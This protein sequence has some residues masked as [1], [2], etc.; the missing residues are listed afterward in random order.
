MI[1]VAS[2]GTLPSEWVVET[3]PVVR[4]RSATRP[5]ETPWPAF[6]IDLATLAAAAGIAA[7]LSIKLDTLRLGVLWPTLLAGALLALLARSGCYRPALHG[8]RLLAHVLELVRQ[9]GAC[10]AVATF[11]VVGTQALAG[12]AGGRQTF[13]LGAAMGGL[14]VSGQIAR[15][16]VAR[17]AAQRQPGGRRTLIVG[18]GEVGCKA[19]RRLLAHPEFGLLPVCFYDEEPRFADGVDG[20]PVRN[21][22]FGSLLERERIE[23]VIVAFSRTP[24]ERLLQLIDDSQR[25]GV[26]VSLVPRLFEKVPTQ[27]VVTTLG[28]LPLVSLRPFPHRSRLFQLKYA[29]ERALAL[30]LL[31][32]GSPLLAALALGVWVSLGR[33][34][35]F[36]Q[37]RVTEGGREFEMLKFR[38]MR[39]GGATA[40][41]P[42]DDEGPGGVE[43][44]DRRSRFGAF[45]R[46]TSLDELPQLLNV[47]RGE[48]SLVGPR[49]ERPEFVRQFNASVYRYAD[50][51]RVRAGITGWAQVHGLRGK[52]SLR[53]RV[54]WDNF[55]I[56]NW[57][58]WFDVKIV[59]MTL[60]AALF[61]GS[62]E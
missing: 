61:S 51:H 33:P 53:D 59:L 17:A 45:I 12:A 9:T 18:A 20:V 37:V 62:A 56:E 29:C 40:F 50:R 4:R 35:V 21:A 2:E 10:A 54:E 8:E 22:D 15:T 32:L 42:G 23:R 3:E 30:V 57:T 5:A 36:R 1:D 25:R 31:V 47:V 44:T 46:R 19:A 48:M 14:V 6:A 38:S 55:Y 7:L 34:I 60:H 28:A 52:T 26:A 58:P 49:P 27:P 11:A 41:S 16:L 13:V 39:P 24:H 43:G